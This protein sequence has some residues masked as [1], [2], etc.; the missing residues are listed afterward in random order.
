M[1]CEQE[2][3]TREEEFTQALIQVNGYSVLR[4]ALSLEKD[5]AV[6]LT[7]QLKE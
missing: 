7:F 3:M 1:G 4:K 2:F 6:Y 5:G